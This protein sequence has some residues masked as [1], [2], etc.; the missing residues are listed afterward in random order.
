MILF[1]FLMLYISMYLGAVMALD[2]TGIE[3]D[4]AWPVTV[5]SHAWMLDPHLLF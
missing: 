4:I 5:T 2:C 1:L 3:K